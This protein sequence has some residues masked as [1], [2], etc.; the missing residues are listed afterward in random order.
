[1]ELKCAGIEEY[2]IFFAIFPFLFIHLFVCCIS[3]DIFTF[4]YLLTSTLKKESL[5]KT[6]MLLI[7]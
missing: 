1:M 5:H 4:Y 7:Q 3:W 6:Y 2:D